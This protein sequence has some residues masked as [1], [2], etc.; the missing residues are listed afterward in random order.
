MGVYGKLMDYRAAVR[1]I[2]ELSK[3]HPYGEYEI[4]KAKA[5]KLLLEASKS[6]RFTFSILRPSNIV[7]LDMPNQ[8][9]RGLVESIIKQGFFISDQSTQFQTTFMK[10]MWLQH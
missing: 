10:M 1:K 2:T 8:S 6:R 5:N 9:F 4:T 3:I 7:G